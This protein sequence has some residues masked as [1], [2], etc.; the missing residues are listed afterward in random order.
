VNPRL[1]IGASLAVLMASGPAAA[2]ERAVALA[3]AFQD[4][5]LSSPPSLAKIDARAQ[6]ARLPLQKGD[7]TDTP[8]EGQV[9]AKVWAVPGGSTGAYALSGGEAVNHGKRVTIC[10]IAAR[11][12]LGDDVRDVLAQPDRLGPPTATRDS[13]DGVQRI[14]EFKAPF[15][16]STILLSDGTPQHAAGVMLNITEVREPGR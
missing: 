4:W 8:A 3:A 6:A 2:S 14:T 13:D 12:A 7:R 15:A 5:C 9:E 11:D 1:A 16:H 10:E